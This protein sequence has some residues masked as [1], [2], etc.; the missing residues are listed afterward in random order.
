[1]SRSL[2]RGSSVDICIVVCRDN[3]TC[4]EIQ[5]INGGCSKICAIAY[6]LAVIVPSDCFRQRHGRGADMDLLTAGCD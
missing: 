5:G 2:R 1:M 6:L 3:G 4:V